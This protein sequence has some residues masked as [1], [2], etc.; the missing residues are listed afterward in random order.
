MEKVTLNRLRWWVSPP[1]VKVIGFKPRSEESLWTSQQR[2][3][4]CHLLAWISN[5]ITKRMAKGHVQFQHT[6]TA[7]KQFD[8]GTPQGSSLSPTLFNYDMNVFLGLEHMLMI[9]SFTVQK[10]EMSLDVYTLHWRCHHPLHHHPVSYF[11]SRIPMP[12]GSLARIK[13]NIYNYLIKTLN[14]ATQSNISG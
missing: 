4:R 6:I 3:V 8:N 13:T 10:V 5:F 7:T 11:P 9:L 14:G 12:H 1:H 2:G